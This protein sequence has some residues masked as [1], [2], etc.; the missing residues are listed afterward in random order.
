MKSWDN[1]TWLLT[2]TVIFLVL[3]LVSLQYLGVSPRTIAIAAAVAVFAVSSSYI[4]LKRRGLSKQGIPQ[5][6]T[7]DW[8]RLAFLI[9]VGLAAWIALIMRFFRS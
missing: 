5:Q 1:L 7:T 9:A 3:T 6:A 2:A 8:R 4:V